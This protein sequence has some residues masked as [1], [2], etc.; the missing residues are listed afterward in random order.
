MSY[1]Q[2]WFNLSTG[3]VSTWRRITTQRKLGNTVN[4]PCLNFRNYE[5]KWAPR[6]L[7]YA[8]RRL[9]IRSHKVLAH[10]SISTIIVRS[11]T[12]LT[13][14]AASVKRQSDAT[15]LTNNLAGPSLH[16][17]L[18][19]KTSYD[20]PKW[21]PGCHGA[22]CLSICQFIAAHFRSYFWKGL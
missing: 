9:I 5:A 16:D 15:I 8:V 14:S 3:D 11:L 22:V 12:D 6:V 7:Q 10:C 1:L 21:P 18:L 17:I 19:Q 13:G 20:T 4:R 2:R